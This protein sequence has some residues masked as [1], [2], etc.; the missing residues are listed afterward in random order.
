M[1]IMPAYEDGEGEE[2]HAREEPAPEPSP[3]YADQVSQCEAPPRSMHLCHTQ[4]DKH[5]RG[6]SSLQ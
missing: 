6:V 2:Q 5:T 1:H 3:S 4:H